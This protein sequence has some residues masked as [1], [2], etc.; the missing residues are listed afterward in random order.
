M[1]R[2]IVLENYMAHARTV[3]EPAAGLTVLIGPNNC[4][5]SAIIHALEMI[6]YNSDA[7]DYAIRHGAKKAMV[8]IETEESDG[9]VHTITWW[10]KERTAGYIIDGREISGLGK[11]KTPDDLHQYLKMPMIESGAGGNEFLLHFGLQKS[12]IFLLDDP[13]TRAAQ[14]FA[15]ATDADKLMQMQR[16]HQQKSSDARRDKQRLDKDVEQLDRELESL[17]PMPLL[18]ERLSQLEDEYGKLNQLGA[19]IGAMKQAVAETERFT[20][21]AA[22]NASMARALARLE[23]PPELPA[24]EPLRRVLGQIESSL[25][26]IARERGRAEAMASLA[27]QPAMQD[28]PSIRSAIRGIEQSLANAEKCG[29]R[30]VGLTKL[31]E[32][33]QIADTRQLAGAIEKLER[34]EA[35]FGLHRAT[36]QTLQSLP[37]APILQDAQALKQHIGKVADSTR[38]CGRMGGKV[39]ALSRLTPPP[40]P[41]DVQPM[42]Q[43][44]EAIGKSERAATE[45]EKLR[46]RANLQLE[47]FGDELAGWVEAHPRCDECGQ[48]ISLELI[49]QGVHSHV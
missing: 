41:D 28:V 13:A 40:R 2:K 49:T 8:T 31:T 29:A 10:R 22:I 45:S 35:R 21:D 19:V 36:Q 42:K 3:I 12:P 34:F 4:G 20:R 32:P 11:G 33:P 47:R 37:A 24:T 44:I 30:S 15:S 17:R 18:A 43:S 23:R 6:C 14:F 5:K 48:A 27:Q 1:I 25:G 39:S 46:A 7:A 16:A 26:R 9:S 38:A